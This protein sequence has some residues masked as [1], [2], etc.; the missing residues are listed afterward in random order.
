MP[1]HL[2]ATAT[3]STRRHARHFALL[4][5]V[6]IMAL[7]LASSPAS[8]ISV[9]SRA[10]AATS[11]PTIASDA[12]RAAAQQ[13]QEA[14]QRAQQSLSRATQA[15]RSMQDIQAA[16]RAA[17]Q[18][19]QA[20]TSRV[21]DG[22]SAGG[23]IV[24]PRV[25][26]GNSGN[27]WVNAKLPTQTTSNG[28]TTVT[29][30][31]TA[32]RA[33]A[34]WQQFN[35]GRNTTLYFDQSGGNSANGNSW[36]IL[37]RI[38]ATGSPSQIL[39]QIR[40]EGTVLIINPNGIIFN[41]T[42]QINVHTL[43][44]SAM[45]LNSFTGTANGAFKA[46][47]DAYVPISVSGL[48]PTAPNGT[49]IL[50]PSDEANANTTFLSNGLFTNAAFNV[51]Y[52]GSSIT[53]GNTALFSAGL[54]P[55]QSNVGVQVQA[56]ASISTDV[57]GFDNGGFVALLG[58]QVSNAGTIST[59]AGQI[60]L[61][62]G[63]S[64]QIAKP[65]SNTTQ[66]SNIVRTGP[67]I[68][69]TL[70]YAP[71][72][73]NGSSLV[74][75]DA[76][77]VLITRRGNI[78]LN[79]DAV[80]QLGFVE[81]TTSITRAGSVTIAANGFAPS[82]QVLFGTKS[83]TAIL[84]EENGETIP[85]DP[86]S[87]ASFVAPRI[88]VSAPYVDFQSGSWVLAPSATM[89]VTGPGQTSPDGSALPPV[90]RVLMESG[91]SIDLSGLT[92]TRSV[93]DYIY[94]FKVTTNDVADTPLARSLVSQT[95]TIDLT[96]TGTRA[97]GETWVGS[98]L[99]ASSGAGYLANVTQGIDQLLTKGGSLT[100]GSGYSVGNG[101]GTTAFVDVL[102]AQGAKIDVS[103]G[104]IQYTGARIATTRVIGSDG[105]NYD[106]SNADPFLTNA[107]VAGFKVD[108][109]RAGVDYTEYYS[110]A[111]H[112]SSYDKPGYFNGVSAGGTSITAVN[113]VLEGD[114]AGEIVIGANQ[115]RLAQRG[116]GAGGAQATPDQLPNG[117]ALAITLV[118][119]G[120]SPGDLHDAVVLQASAP[121]VLAPDFSIASSLLLP[122]ATSGT[123]SPK[124][125]SV[126]AYST[127]KLT[128]FGLGS[129]SISGADTL[130]IAAGA[131]LSVLDA[132]S[133]KLGS[134]STVDGTLTAHGGSITLAGP[135]A[136][137]GTTALP[138]LVIGAHA[139]L[140]VSGRW[141]ND[142]GATTD[143]LAGALS[144]NG[145]SISLSTYNI[146]SN[147]GTRDL[148]PSI[149]LSAGSVVDV[150][151][152]GYVS[153]SGTLAVGADGL[154]KG[155]GGNL[156]LL[157]YAGT[158]LDPTIIDPNAPRSSVPIYAPPT[159]TNANVLMNGSIYAGG[160][161]Q[162][163]TFALQVPEIK[164][165]G[166]ATQVTAITSGPQ[167]GTV[168]LPTSFFTDSGFG[169]FSL[170]STY[171]ST[172]VTAGT[173][174]TL[175]QQNYQ[176][177]AA[178]DL[179]ATGARLRQFAALGYALDGLRHAVNLTLAQTGYPY[180]VTGDRG[181][182]SKLLI[183]EGARIVGDPLASISLNAGGPAVILGS[184][185]APGGNISISEGGVA[186]LIPRQRR[187]APICLD[188]R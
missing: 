32:Q 56:G 78:T 51:V 31:Q 142:T 89:S 57:S 43:I 122:T 33:I 65:G 104:V 80:E 17:A 166:R 66:T 103:G 132:G 62:A 129:I 115:R 105:R 21:T 76:G 123:A 29:V 42:S 146:S 188:R 97:D 60:I 181:A 163:G 15:L 158:W 118:A 113:P 140:D 64:V 7:T 173:T 40:A 127:D 172:T 102:Q 58:P 93:S 184:I 73:V 26:A 14:A 2:S 91:S 9:G 119:S 35:V 147:D 23:L 106:I 50:A 90:G 110:D 162:G 4:A 98:P 85:S 174:V 34:T 30:Q 171:G 145:G 6:S 143:G 1:A 126:I 156:S 108:H 99:F 5:S 148:S 47:G 114:L 182:L 176:L 131:S 160:L 69:G 125:T 149:I 70:L 24:D 46:S 84:P 109:P 180:G 112:G 137:V 154:P 157:T 8:A 54:I 135:Q 74:L 28:Q 95:V 134:V 170:T 81:A 13:A 49:L 12:A 117:A 82:N 38:D 159:A 183:D 59:S 133:I 187:S 41:G 120:I 55:A 44:A 138:N 83:V 36:T 161:S 144:I 52:N 164:V 121:S 20:Q 18:A 37:N 75:N 152:G 169:S 111:L 92:A 179:P 175:K 22:L 186:V 136:A 45:D 63:S 116:T 71:P 178:T 101:Q 100:F 177:T 168:V 150:S 128:S 11:A 39:G 167:A 86:T 185:T 61:A 77:G 165:D 151:S 53:T 155:K 10:S 124:T 19:Q 94:T 107:I 27:L 141:V 72:S 48:T 67:A 153:P 139:L 88:D 25:A 79:G 130:S 16:A 87:L 3:G 68:S 96:Q